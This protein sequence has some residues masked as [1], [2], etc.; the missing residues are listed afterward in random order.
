VIGKFEEENG[1]VYGWVGVMLV[2]GRRMTGW[3]R[4][5]RWR[6]GMDVDFER[7][8]GVVEVVCCSVNFCRWLKGMVSEGMF[9]PV[10]GQGREGR[11]GG[12][13]EYHVVFS[14]GRETWRGSGL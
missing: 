2:I 3:W 12:M 10:G 13:G 9:L 11:C 8:D 5:R 4:W 1:W 14:A 6:V 7:N